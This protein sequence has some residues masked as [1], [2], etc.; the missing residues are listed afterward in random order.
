[1]PHACASIHT[2]TYLVL[3]LGD[4]ARVVAPCGVGVGVDVDAVVAYDRI[5]HTSQI[6]TKKRGLANLTRKTVREGK[7]RR[8]GAWF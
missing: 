4:H 5:P 7:T 1:M 8:T 2:S 6:C 3:D